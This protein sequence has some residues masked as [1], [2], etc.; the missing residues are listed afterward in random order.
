MQTSVHDRATPVVVAVGDSVRP[1]RIKPTIGRAVVNAFQRHLRAVNASRPNALGGRRTNFYNAAAGGTH[2]DI[3]PDGV[4][5]SVNQVGLRQRVRGGTISPTRRK[6]LTV[7]A[8]AEAHGKRASEFDDLTVVFGVRGQP[9]ALAHALFRRTRQQL[10]GLAPL[11]R[12]GTTRSGNRHG[13]IVFWLRTQV[14][15]PPDPSVVPGSLAIAAAAISAVNADRDRLVQR[16][17]QQAGGAT[18]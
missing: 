10:R 8:V 11:H 15:Q 12:L 13:G 2:F 17:R 5:I 16:A 1:E 18:A 3:L 7:P 6:F 4:M 9:I 14:T